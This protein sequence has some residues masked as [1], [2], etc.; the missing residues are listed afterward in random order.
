MNT[1]F[2]DIATAILVFALSISLAAV[3]IA[4]LL[5]A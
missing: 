3:Q 1:F 2:D 4:T 5:G